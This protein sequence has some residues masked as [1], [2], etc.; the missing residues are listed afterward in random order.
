MELR[1]ER[2][3]PS[4]TR[5]RIARGIGV[6]AA[7]VLIAGIAAAW[8]QWNP[9][10]PAPR[11]AATS[12]SASADSGGATVERALALSGENEKTRWVDEVPGVDVSALDASQRVVFLQVVNGRRCTCGCGYTLAACRVHDASCDVS[13]PRVEAVRDSVRR[14]WIA[15]AAEGGVALE[16]HEPP[17]R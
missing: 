11:A 5:S 3:A 2:P 17:R 8:R 7:L 14:G 16:D 6:A 9:S 12:P 13:L 1:P 15:N 10:S 4:P